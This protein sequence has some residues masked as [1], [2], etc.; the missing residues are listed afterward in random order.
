ML[1]IR[2]RVEGSVE[3]VSILFQCFQGSFQMFGSLLRLINFSLQEMYKQ[4]AQKL[5]ISKLDFRK[6]LD[7]ASQQTHQGIVPSILLHTHLI[8]MYDPRVQS[9]L[10][11]A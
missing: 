9:D 6:H 2:Y 11:K 1:V 7:L 5:K 4:Q 8:H 3:E 10:T